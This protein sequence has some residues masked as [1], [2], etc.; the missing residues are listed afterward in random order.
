[1]EF[2]ATFLVSAI[3]FI[4]FV[5]LMN[6][7][8]YAPLEKIITEREKLVD[9]TL[10]DAKTSRENA[11]T[12]LKDRE[13]KLNMASEQGKKLVTDMVEKANVK[14]RDL[15]VQAKTNSIETLNSK[16]MDLISQK[17]AVKAD[18]DNTVNELAKQIAMKI[19]G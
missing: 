14:S 16:K 4:L 17:D 10:N 11:L 9:D 1:M 8:F 3:S 12:L 13:D 2:N 7:I 6:K 19:T 15:T 5:Y 18:L